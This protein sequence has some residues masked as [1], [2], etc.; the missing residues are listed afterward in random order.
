LIGIR[1][2]A[3]NAFIGIKAFTETAGTWSIRIGE[4]LGAVCAC[5]RYRKFAE[6]P[7]TVRAERAS[8]VGEGAAVGAGGG[9]CEIN[10]AGDGMAKQ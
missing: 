4:W 10:Q 1:A 9:V 8:V 3:Y 6:F 2:Q 5:G 7:I